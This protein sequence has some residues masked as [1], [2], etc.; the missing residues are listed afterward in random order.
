MTV[1]HQPRFRIKWSLCFCSILGSAKQKT[2]IFFAY[3]SCDAV[4]RGCRILR[5][6]NGGSRRQET[7]LEVR[8]PRTTLNKGRDQEHRATIECRAPRASKMRCRLLD[9]TEG[10]FVALCTTGSPSL[11]VFR[12]VSDNPVRQR[13]ARACRFTCRRQLHRRF[14]AS[15]IRLYCCKWRTPK[16]ILPGQPVSKQA[17]G[18]EIKRSRRQKAY[19]MVSCQVLIGGSMLVIRAT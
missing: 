7:G 1:Q 13:A 4:L 2:T 18:C 8:L 11:S 17:D 12:F 3:I 15:E 5:G 19:L 14:L 9:C 6:R 16:P 10:L